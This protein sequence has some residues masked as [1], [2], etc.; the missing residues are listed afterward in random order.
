MNPYFDLG[1]AFILG[2]L[3]GCFVVGFYHA[4]VCER[5]T[6]MQDRQRKLMENLQSEVQRLELATKGIFIA[7]VQ[8]VIDDAEGK[9]K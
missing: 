5:F 2:L 4:D 1:L 8:H 9:D 7:K 3:S 6:A